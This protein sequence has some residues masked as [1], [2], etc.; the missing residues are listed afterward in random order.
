MV[1]KVR[2]LPGGS[3]GGLTRDW[4]V[5]PVDPEWKGHGSGE[6]LVTFDTNGFGNGGSPGQGVSSSFWG[7]RKI[8]EGGSPEGDRNNLL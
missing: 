5:N 8:W 4:L 6:I 1:F 3:S 2:R 7:L